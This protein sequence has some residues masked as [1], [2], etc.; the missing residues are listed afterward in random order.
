MP[1]ENFV[2]PFRLAAENV[3][4]VAMNVSW[5]VFVLLVSLAFRSLAQ[6]D[7]LS[8]SHESYGVID[9][10]LISGNE[11]TKD[12]IILDEMTLK[13]GS[14]ATPEAI[15]FDRNR[16]Y[17]LGLFTRVDI[18]YG[19]SEGQRLLRVDVSERWYLIPV[20]IFGFRDGDPKRPYYGGGLLHN[21]FRGRNQKLLGLIVFGHNPSLALSFF[22]PL[23]DDN[24]DL[25]FDT[26]LSFSKI[27][28]KSIV[29]STLA[30]DYDE[31]HYNLSATIGKRFSL[32]QWAGI[33]LGYQIV[34]VTDPYPWRTTAA[35]GIDRFLYGGISYRFDSRDLR[36]Y[37]SEGRF[38]SVYVTKSGFGESSISYTRFGTDFRTY[39]PLPLSLTFAGRVHGTIVSGGRLP[40]YGHVFF[41]YGERIRGY[42]TTVFEGE[43]MVGTT[44][45]LRYPLVKA[46]DIHVTEVPLPP[47][48]SVWRFG[49]SV[50]IF[51]DAGLVWC[52]SSTDECP[53]PAIRADK[54][55]FS[56]FF[57][58][59]GAGIRFLLPYGV[60]VRTEYAYNEYFEG[61][62]ILD[63]RATL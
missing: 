2:E 57:S 25:Y 16:I 26:G 32:Y 34:E 13:P 60:V 21:N 62:F 35:D 4:R 54:I 45:E 11:K 43:N 50:A 47:E 59:Y 8:H 46:F 14:E 15:E 63:F 23:I 10:I 58:G 7:S 9:T 3:D 28:N 56:S 53:E 6:S 22:D 39:I 29:Q 40:T 17:S 48:F 20:P 31:L 5:T 41:G 38:L 44:V 36:E 55:Q 61:Q 33:T 30:G 12:Y 49:I 18:S 52:R 51:A 42:F 24:H 37:P 1:L 19:I 27:R